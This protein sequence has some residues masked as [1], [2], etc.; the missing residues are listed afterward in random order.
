MLIAEKKWFSI[1]LFIVLAVS[2]ASCDLDPI[3]RVVRAI[4]KQANYNK[5]ELPYTN[6]TNSN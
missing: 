4:L 6:S 1:L 5:N 2:I 3:P